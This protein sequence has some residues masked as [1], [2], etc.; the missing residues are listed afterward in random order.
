MNFSLKVILSLISS[1]AKV[2][3]LSKTLISFLKLLSKAFLYALMML[4]PIISIT[5][6]L[7]ASVG[8]A[9]NA[10]LTDFIA[11]FL[12]FGESGNSNKL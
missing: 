10:A 6:F 9:V 2:K 5:F 7:S 8:Q 11:I 12:I 4:S 1:K 3:A